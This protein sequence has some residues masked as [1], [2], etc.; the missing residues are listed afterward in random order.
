MNRKTISSIAVVAI[1]V[2]AIVAV[3]GGYVISVK[4]GSTSFKTE[5]ISSNVSKYPTTNIPVVGQNDTTT[6]TVQPT[7][8]ITAVT[9]ITYETTAPP[10]VEN[11]STLA[12]T[13]NWN[14]SVYL[15]EEINST[16]ISNPYLGFTVYYYFDNPTN[17]DV[18]LQSI[19]KFPA[20]G[21][22][23]EICIPPILPALYEG[24]YT[25][26]NFSEATP[27]S[28]IPIGGTTCPL[29][30]HARF[31]TFS[32]AAILSNSFPIPGYF[33]ELP[34]CTSECWYTHQLNLGKYT[35]AVGDE[36]GDLTLLYVTVS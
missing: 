16:T 27:L 34:N 2:I 10:P 9:T 4:S 5:T 20:P 7:T 18:T 22:V 28:I 30:I 11:S 23:N 15:V 21:M 26:A 12:A 14:S 31:F 25:Q 1:L 36:W 35:V 8:S 13:R 33:A 32:N 3:S 17:Q 6:T 19:W 24:Y 29:F